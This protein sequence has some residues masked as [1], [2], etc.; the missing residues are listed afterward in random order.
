MSTTLAPTMLAENG[1]TQ[2]AEDVYIRPMLTIQRATD[3]YLGDLS[4]AGRRDRTTR[5]YGRVLDQFIDQ[6]PVDTDVAEIKPD[7][8]RRF[9]DRH[10]RLSR[11]TQAQVF[12]ILNGFF[13]WARMNEKIKRSPMERM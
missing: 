7:D 2:V 6:L 8:V 1:L 4:R 12:S 11:G 13:K 5:T 10:L 9:L 3:L